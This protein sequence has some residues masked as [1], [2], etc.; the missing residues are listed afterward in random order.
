MLPLPGAFRAL[1][2]LLL[3]FF[4]PGPGEKMCTSIMVHVYSYVCVCV[5]MRVYVCVCVRVCVSM[6]VCTCVC[7]FVSASEGTHTAN[8]KQSETVT[9]I[10]MQK[11][12]P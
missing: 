3:A 1:F 10:D 4:L 12:K 5:C 2:L 11:P 9:S 6:H 8:V 7:D